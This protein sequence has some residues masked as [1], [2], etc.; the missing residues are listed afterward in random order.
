MTAVTALTHVHLMVNRTLP[1]Q[2]GIDKVKDLALIM[3]RPRRDGGNKRCFCPS[4]C[5]SVRRVHSE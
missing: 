5:V 4:V 1:A 2:L 3:P